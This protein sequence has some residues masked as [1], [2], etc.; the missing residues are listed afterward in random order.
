MTQYDITITDLT[1]ELNISPFTVSRALNDHP[2][3]NNETS[4][5]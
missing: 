3:I 5:D 4:S 1:R 2:A